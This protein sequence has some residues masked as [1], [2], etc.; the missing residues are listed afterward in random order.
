MNEDCNI[1]VNK[2]AIQSTTATSN[3]SFN[4][5]VAVSII[6]PPHTGIIQNHDVEEI[7]TQVN[8]TKDE[9]ASVRK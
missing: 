6:S 5:S 8:L 9:S 1:D 3:V 4:N 2:I 7:V